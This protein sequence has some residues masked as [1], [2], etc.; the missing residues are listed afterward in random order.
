MTSQTAARTAQNRPNVLARV[1]AV[2][3]LLAVAAIA[4]TVTLLLARHVGGDA[5]AMLHG[6]S[7]MPEPVRNLLGGAEL[8]HLSR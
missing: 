4:I 8:S 3:L 5:H 7:H 1:G 2:L 6:I